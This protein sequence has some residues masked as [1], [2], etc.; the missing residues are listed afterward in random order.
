V[1]W[2]Q[3][4]QRMGPG[5]I[6]G[7]GERRGGFEKNLATFDSQQ[8]ATLKPTM[9]TMQLMKTWVPRRCGYPAAKEVSAFIH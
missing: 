5:S 2:R 4:R 3:E 1:D 8:L 9:S 6:E 7:V